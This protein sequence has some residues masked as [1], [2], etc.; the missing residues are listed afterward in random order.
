MK[1]QKLFT[2]GSISSYGAGHDVKTYIEM[3][4]IEVNTVEINGQ[5]FLASEEDLKRVKENALH[6][7]IKL[8]ERLKNDQRVT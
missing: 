6:L 3:G 7:E 4:M 2:A 1:T 5:R 8:Q